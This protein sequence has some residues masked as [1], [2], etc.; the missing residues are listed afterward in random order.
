M[1]PTER[2]LTPISHEDGVTCYYSVTTPPDDS[3]AVVHLYPSRVIPVIFVPGV[4]GSNLKSNDGKNTPVWTVN[5]KLGVARAWIFKNAAQRKQLLDPDKTEVD[6]RGELPSGSSLSETEMRRRGWGTVLNAFYG[7][8]LVWLENHLHD[9]AVCETGLRANMMEKDKAPEVPGLSFDEVENSYRYDFPVYAVGYNSLQS[10]ID[11]AK[12][13]AD[14]IWSII[15]H[16]QTKKKPQKCEKVILVTHSMGGLVARWF[17]GVDGRTTAEAAKE[18]QQTPGREKVMGIVHGVMPTTGSG[19]TYARVRQ[20]TKGADGLVMGSDAAK[21]TAVFAQSPGPLQLLPSVQYGMGW[22]RIIAGSG[23]SLSLPKV[24]PYS[25]IYTQRD[26]WWG[27]IQSKLINPLDVTHGNVDK[28]WKNLKDIIYKKVKPFHDGLYD[29]QKGCG[30]FH[31]C[32]YVFYGDDAE[33]KTYGEV[34]WRQSGGASNSVTS[35]A[36]DDSVLNAASIV[37]TLVGTEIIGNPGNRFAQMTF[38]IWDPSDNGDGTVPTR[39]GSAPNGQKGVLL[40]KGYAGIDHAAAYMS[41]QQRRFALWSI[42]KIAVEVKNT[43]LAYER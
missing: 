18:G 34:I 15:N 23:Y 38:E 31:P 1:S 16:Y 10:N 26:R 30:K 43:S 19:E 29:A 41:E 40:C 9:Y 13:L 17:S 37:D 35:P 24:E 22:L 21:M 8:F 27:L 25:E 5:S 14:E 32:T 6:E 7:D 36:V 33:K 28:D 12:H 2:I 4:M 11:S 20:G 39:S 3:I 42:V